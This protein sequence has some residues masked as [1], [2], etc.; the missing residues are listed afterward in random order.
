[1]CLPP[2]CRNVLIHE[3]VFK[4]CVINTTVGE[5]GHC[6]NNPGDYSNLSVSG[7]GG[8]RR[9]GR[10]V[11]R[12]GA[13]LDRQVPAALLA[14]VHRPGLSAALGSKGCWGGGVRAGTSQSLPN[15]LREPVR[16]LQSWGPTKASDRGAGAGR[17]PGVPTPCPKTPRDPHSQA[18]SP[19]WG[20]KE[21]QTAELSPSDLQ[22]PPPQQAE[23]APGEWAPGAGAQVP[24][25][26]QGFADGQVQSKC[27]LT[28]RAGCSA[29]TATPGSGG[30]CHPL[31][32]TAPSLGREGP[33]R[34]RLPHLDPD[35][36]QAAGAQGRA[37]QSR[38]SPPKRH[39]PL[40]TPCK[41]CPVPCG[42]SETSPS[43]SPPAPPAPWEELAPVTAPAV[44]ATPPLTSGQK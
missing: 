44:T 39:P 24:T 13:V 20:S 17:A 6:E 10:R 22:E 38:G 31:T 33:P 14:C 37:A 16:S 8:D 4:P 43:A 34:A 11:G 1:M 42:F 27:P 28:G 19:P 15:L 30:T 5:G 23:L 9:A 36:D 21:P 2:A 32:K 7:R 12:E 29:S 35:A 18:P 41:C 3:F 25:A 40:G 26:H